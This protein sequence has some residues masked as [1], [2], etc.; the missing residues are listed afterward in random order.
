MDR[1]ME[2][3]EK[4]ESTNQAQGRKIDELTRKMEEMQATIEQYRVSIA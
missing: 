1:L 2:K 4:S 3:L